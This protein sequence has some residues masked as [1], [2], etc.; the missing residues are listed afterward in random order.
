MILHLTAWAQTHA[1]ILAIVA[2]MT[3]AVGGYVLSVDSRIDE[4][5]TGD[6]V[7]QDQLDRI[8]TDV[9]QIRCMTIEAYQG[10]DPLDCLNY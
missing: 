9:Q 7:R 10:G 3:G 8:E 4:I 6:F 5:E 1:K 2:S